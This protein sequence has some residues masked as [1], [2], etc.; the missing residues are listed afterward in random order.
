MKSLT[1]YLLESEQVFLSPVDIERVSTGR[2]D[3]NFL[4]TNNHISSKNEAEHIFNL[5]KDTKVI[6]SDNKSY[7][8]DFKSL[9]KLLSENDTDLYQVSGTKL[10]KSLNPEKETIDDLTNDLFNEFDSDD[11]E[12]SV[13]NKINDALAE[14]IKKYIIKSKNVLDFKKCT[15]V[16]FGGETCY[17]II[18]TNKE[19]LKYIDIQ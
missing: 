18:V 5:C 19:L 6:D 7:E 16:T 8:D 1:Q 15:F 12:E 10:E 4:M 13:D 9:K 14:I 2:V 3:V 17:I 11:T